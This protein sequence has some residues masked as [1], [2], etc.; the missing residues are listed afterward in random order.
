[1]WEKNDC[2]STNTL[3]KVYKHESIVFRNSREQRLIDIGTIDKSN[4]QIECIQIE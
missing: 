3:L 4:I 2:T 1:M